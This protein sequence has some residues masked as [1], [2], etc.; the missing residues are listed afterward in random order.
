M[1]DLK[2]RVCAVI[3]DL[4]CEFI[5]TSHRIH[6]TPELMFKEFKSAKMLEALL[7]KHGMTV[8]SGIAGMPTA[9]KAWATTG[10]PGTCG[11]P[12][13]RTC[14]T[15]GT[16]STSAAPSPTI[17]ILGEYDALPGVGHA[18]GHN[19]IGTSAAAAGIALVKALGDVP[20]T[21]AVFG[22]PA[23]EGGGGKIIMVREGWF[24][25]VDAAMMTH[26]LPGES[27]IGGP[28]LATT[29]FVVKY[30][31]K[32]AHAAASPH[33]GIN[34]LDAIMIAFTAISY[35]RQQVTE[36]VRMHGFVAQGGEASNIIPEY[37]EARYLVRAEKRATV[38]KIAERV[39]RCFEA[40]ALATG[41]RLEITEGMR[42][43][44]R[45]INHTLAG[46]LRDNMR[47]LGIQVKDE[48][49]KVRGSTDF[50][51]VSQVVPAVNAYL[52]IAPETVASHSREM[53]EASKSPVGDKGLLDAAKAMAMTA[54][55]LICAP[56]LLRKAH[57]EFELTMSRRK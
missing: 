8:E 5:E 34:A 56:A 40:G 44:E 12:S 42:Y 51:E 20:A 43:S 28:N 35:L 26:P 27:M 31:G 16:S 32:A 49:E 19:I 18:C 21:I 9:F 54:V 46:L 22:C 11:A 37:A 14:G 47:A 1:E 7:A 45:I 41:A 2:A 50:G 4:A 52:S 10:A 53:A 13:S 38:D 55:D 6:E 25:G 3:D 17:A 33:D 15:P 39:R 57:D 29:S 48:I 36:D 23:E 30:Y 24:K